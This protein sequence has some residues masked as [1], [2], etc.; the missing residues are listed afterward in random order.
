MILDAH[1]IIYQ[2]F[3]TMREMIGPKG[4]ATD[5]A[6]GF[7]RDVIGLLLKFEP[8]AIFCAFDMP[9]KTFRH[10]IYAEYKANR[11]PMPED[12]R[13]QLIFVRQ[14]LEGLCV[15]RLELEL[16]EAD[17]IL[18][19]GARRASDAGGEVILVTSDKDARQLISDRVRL[20]NLRKESLYGA[21]ELKADWGI[22][23][24]QVIDFQ[25]MVGDATDNI[26]GIPLIGPKSAADLLQ[27]YDTL[28][29]IF[30]RAGEIKGKKGANIAAARESSEISRA[31][32]TLDTG[33]PIEIDWEKGVPR[34]VDPNRLG[35]L[36]QTFGFRSLLPQI[37]KLTERFGSRV[38][39]RD[40]ALDEM[41]SLTEKKEPTPSE[42]PAP[43]AQQRSLS[44][45][46]RLSRDSRRRDDPRRRP[47]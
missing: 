28:E 3:H 10:E 40:A 1:G 12:L 16:Y 30:R 38:C 22:R 4:Q 43:A 11:P 32:V 25:T 21:E 33:V 18:A 23:P 8:D 44:G 29:E 13:P 35:E 41:Y 34:G 19:T 36:F 15:P 27:K 7:T 2:V 17:D 37:D 47:V 45:G 20:Y 6:Y 39:E 9:G 26:P 24:D 42:R 31:L 5:A 14:I 46:E